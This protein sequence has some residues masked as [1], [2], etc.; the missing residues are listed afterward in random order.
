[1]VVAA[2]II[3]VLVGYGA[4]LFRY[5]ILLCTWTFS[6]GVTDT[7]SGFPLLP[8][9]WILLMPAAGGLVVGILVTR[10]APEA[11][12][13]GIPE[14]MEAVALHDGH[15]RKRVG[16][17]KAIVVAIC[18]GSGGSAGREGP[19]VHIGSAVGSLVGKLFR[20]SVSQVRT[21]VGCGAAAGI[22]ATFNAPI[23]GAMFAGE[24]IL[25]EFGVVRFSAI[26]ISSVMATVL[27]RHHIGDFPAFIVPAFQMH[28][29]YELLCY[30]ALG[31][32]AALVGCLFILGLEKSRDFFESMPIP[33]NTKPAV[34]G[35]LVGFLGIWLPQIMGVGY[36]SIND[37]MDKALPWLLVLA[38]LFGKILASSLTLG[39]GGSGGIFAPSLFMGAALGGAFGMGLHEVL[40]HEVGTTGS[41]A[42]VAMGAVVA[43]TTR[44]PISSIVIIF[45][46]T[47]NYTIILPLMISCI[48]AA[49]LAGQLVR[50]S[51][52]H[53]KLLRR[54]VDLERDYQLNVL[55]RIKV[56]SAPLERPQYL[57][58]DASMVEI[59]EKVIEHGH[60][61]YVVVD[62]REHYVGLIHYNELRFL[63]FNEE[64]LANLIVAADL[65][66]RDVPVLMPT[67]SLDL[68]LKLLR[69]NGLDALPVL[70]PVDPGRLMGMI[71]RNAVIDTYNRE[72]FNRDMV[73][74]TAGLMVTA[75]R[76]RSVSLGDEVLMMELEVPSRFVG[77]T[78]K[79]LDLRR[80][81]D[82]QV[83]LVRRRVRDGIAP[84]IRR[85][86][87][88][89]DFQL[90]QGD[91]MLLLGGRESLERI[92]SA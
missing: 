22:A 80:K 9:W 77:M 46:M 69:E 11:K 82:V 85:E 31:F 92:A 6:G 88:G 28:H 91:V 89:P 10:L 13:S 73:G 25:G 34:G 5:L 83:M 55:H 49:L 18:L 12:G 26:V 81:Y 37:I 45:E 35:L 76:A 68:A 47:N 67:D 32:L 3:G 50:P 39:S 53:T 59:L 40:P 58:E 44:A 48:L 41:Y 21:F 52:Y 27:S 42:L 62:Q 33:E 57:K 74:E 90:G 79:E 19:I 56:A 24:V 7:P 54:G 14:V 23:A 87:P 36:G 1:M 64:V 72:V 30:A 65:A 60:P 8:W 61:H 63:L 43:A 75:E 78:L 2:V 16:L 51:I 70:S 86:I 29:T 4:I 84:R 66:H 38:L 17:I 71:T 15:I 20:V